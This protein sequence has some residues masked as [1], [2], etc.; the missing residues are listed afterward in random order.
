MSVGRITI[1]PRMN[2]QRC[3]TEKGFG[4][5]IPHF[6]LRKTY[7]TPQLPYDRGFFLSDT[8]SLYDGTLLLYDGTFSLHDDTLSLYYGTL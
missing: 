3:F 2:H 6:G 4:Y 5:N 8:L 7:G 1:E